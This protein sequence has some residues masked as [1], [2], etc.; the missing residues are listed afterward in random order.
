M[1]SDSNGRPKPFVEGWSRR[2][3]PKAH[4]LDNPLGNSYDVLKVLLGPP[5][6]PLGPTKV[7]YDPLFPFPSSSLANFSGGIKGHK[8]PL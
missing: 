3:R 4:I 7:P 2:L 8:G 6:G 5:Y 1:L